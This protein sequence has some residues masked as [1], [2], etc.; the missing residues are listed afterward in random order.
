MGIAMAAE[1]AVA[2]GAGK[3][4]AVHVA[5]TEGQGGAVGAG[6]DEAFDAE[7]R[8]GELRDRPGVGP[9]PRLDAARAAEGARPGVGD[10]ALRQPGFGL[11]P[12]AAPELPGA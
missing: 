1:D 12:G 3:G 4:G 9:S 2:G 11:Y 7:A 8:D 6:E 5:G 10:Q